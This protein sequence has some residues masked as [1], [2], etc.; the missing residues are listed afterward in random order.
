[1]RRVLK[2]E[3]V[4]RIVV[5]DLEVIVR[6]YLANLD[7]AERGDSKAALRYDWMVLE[8]LDQMSRR[9]CGGEMARF[10]QCCPQDVRSFIVSRIGREAESFWTNGGSKKSMASRLLAKNVAWYVDSVR[11]AIV[12]SLA[13]LVGGRKGRQA[14]REGWFLGRGEVHRWMYDR[15]SLKRKLIDVGFSGVKTCRPDESMIPNFNEYWLDM[16]GEQVR[17]PD[18]LFVEAKRG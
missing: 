2:P 14:V 15:R 1:M 13:T 5:P 17:K 12:L 16:C 11:Y 6:A 4:V 10:I 7:D 8:L 18:S 9:S 3:G